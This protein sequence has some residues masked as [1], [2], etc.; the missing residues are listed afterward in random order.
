LIKTYLLDAEHVLSTSGLKLAL[1][2]DIKPRIA[3]KILVL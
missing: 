1:L 2:R 3:Y